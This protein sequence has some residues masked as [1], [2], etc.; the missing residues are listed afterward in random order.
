MPGAVLF[1][2]GTRFTSI[3]IVVV[4]LDYSLPSEDRERGD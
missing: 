3:G 4:Q 2:L 1:K